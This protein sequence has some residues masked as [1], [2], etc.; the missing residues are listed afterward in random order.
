MPVM[1]NHAAQSVTRNGLNPTYSPA[2]SGD[3]VDV[4]EHVVLHVKNAGG[5]PVTLTLTTPGNVAG[6][7]VADLAVTI[8]AGGE[9]FV[10]P[11]GADLFR[12]SADGKAHLSWS[13]TTS[14]T[15]AV[16]AL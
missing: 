11:V 9:R 15:F 5:S 2:A 3:T 4:G 14:V 10:G 13:A 1:A 7:A 16:L 6:L 8:P 12:D